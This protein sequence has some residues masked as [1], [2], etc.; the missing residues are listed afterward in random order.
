VAGKAVAVSV[1]RLEITVPDSDA[2]D[3]A[4]KLWSGYAGV[5]GGHAHASAL[6]EVIADEKALGDRAI[7]RAAGYF[8]RD[9]ER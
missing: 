1:V 4:S 7:L 2:H 8:M 3:V 5:I 6:V 9:G